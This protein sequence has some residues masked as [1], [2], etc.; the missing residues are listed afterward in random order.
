WICRLWSSRLGNGARCLAARI[1]ILKVV[2]QTEAAEKNPYD[3]NRNSDRIDVKLGWRLPDFANRRLR[4]L[5]HLH[6]GLLGLSL[7]KCSSRQRFWSG[8]FRGDFLCRCRFHN[9]NFLQGR[10]LANVREASRRHC[11]FSGLL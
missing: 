11:N 10:K 2:I 8:L 3:S 5:A 9:S 7:S 1:A 4:N 6:L